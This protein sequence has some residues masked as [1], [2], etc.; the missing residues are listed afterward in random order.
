VA[1]PVRFYL[2]E[3]VHPAIAAGLRRL[4]VDVLT[5]QEA[6]LLSADDDAHLELAA[7]KGRV[8]FT[9]DADFLRLHRAGVPHG[10][11]AYAPQGTPI[12]RVVRGLMLIYEV[13]N[14]EDMV[15]RVEFL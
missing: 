11:I 10:G 9:Q 8:V 1:E 6:G 13:L 3:H 2:D 12:G 4:G 14:A 15:R 5:A 7:Q